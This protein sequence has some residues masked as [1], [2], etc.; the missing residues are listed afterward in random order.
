M[1]K[2]AVRL[3]PP[4]RLHFH[5]LW[6]DRLRWLWGE[7]NR[8]HLGG[9]LRPAVLSIDCDSHAVLGRWRRSLRE[10]SISEA[11]ILS[12]PWPEVEQTLYHEMA[13]QFADEVLQAHDEAAHGPAFAEACRRLRVEARAT[14]RPRP[15]GEAADK[16][17]AKVKKLLA[18]AE[19]HNVH[20]AEVAMA[21]AN[22]LLLQHNLELVEARARR[23]Y[24]VRRVGALF[25]AVPVT[26]KLVS[27]ILSEFFFVEAV[28]T[29]EYVALQDETLR[30]LELLGS[31]TNLEL[32]CYVHDFLHHACQ[33]LWR[34]AQDRH[35]GRSARREF[36]AGVLLG[37]RDKLRAERSHSRAQGLVW[38]GDADLD[39][40]VAA[41]H[42]ELRRM[43]SGSVGRTSALSAGRAA[44]QALQ[45]HHGVTHRG[46]GGKRLTR[47]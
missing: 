26:A 44:G 31:D 5:P 40:F 4:Q 21:T 37:F 34:A 36:E 7:A 22:R 38:V 29:S 24:R 14:M 16:V 19:S 41:E 11:H 13:H 23:D 33:R 1:S 9:A 35:V 17:L 15:G 12:H 27:A 2:P 30:R 18:L 6:L 25:K 46:E 47:A 20:E 42:P 43:A 45:L 28:W 3:L 8:R 39:A 32:A 10:I